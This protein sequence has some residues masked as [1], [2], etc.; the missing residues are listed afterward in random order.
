[1]WSQRIEKLQK[2]SIRQVN[3]EINGGDK[4][5][6]PKVIR[7]N[8]DQIQNKVEDGEAKD[9]FGQEDVAEQMLKEDQ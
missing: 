1:M 5:M 9:I 4:V 8:A 2:G 7:V 3:D 6:D